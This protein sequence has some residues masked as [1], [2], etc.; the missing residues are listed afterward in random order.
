MKRK[1]CLLAS[2]VLLFAAPSAR[3]TTCSI[4][5]VVAVSFGAYNVF[6]S[7]PVD[8]SG[9]VTYECSLFGVLDIIV[10]DISA[11][12]SGTT[13]LRTMKQGMYSLNYNLYTDAARSVVWG[14]GTGM[15]GHYGPVTL[16]LFPVT[17]PIY[18]RIAPLQ[19]AR[20]GSYS[21]TVTITMLF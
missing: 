10:I 13:T 19:N 3:A 9:S 6:S 5:A 18:G 20:A 8:S 2:A 7:S 17:V 11:G 4:N 14:N 1:L 16:N 15:T 12:S 21:D